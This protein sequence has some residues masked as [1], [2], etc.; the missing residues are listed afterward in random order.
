MELATAKLPRPATRQEQ[1]LAGREDLDL[2]HVLVGE[3]RCL[4]I[5]VQISGLSNACSEIRLAL[6]KIARGV[7][8]LALDDR[9]EDGAKRR[10]LGQGRAAFRRRGKG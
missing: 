3:Q 10:Q 2:V 6:P 8:D 1:F 9:V 4:L 5:R 7:L